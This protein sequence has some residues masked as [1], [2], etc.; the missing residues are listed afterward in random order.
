MTTF[1]KAE[2]KGYQLTEQY[3]LFG[4]TDHELLSNTDKS[5]IFEFKDPLLESCFYHTEGNKLTHFLEQK[6]SGYALIAYLAQ[7]ALDIKRFPW[8]KDR[9]L[10]SH[11]ENCTKDVE[12]LYA[13]LTIERINALIGEL[14]RLYEHTQKHLKAKGLTHV[15]LVRH[16]TSGDSHMNNSRSSYTSTV[17]TLKTC[18]E[19]AEVDA[20]EFEMDVV[21]SYSCSLG[22]YP[23]LQTVTLYREVPIEDVLCCSAFLKIN[24]GGEW[25]ILNRMPDGIVSFKP[26]DIIF[27]DNVELLITRKR[28]L[29]KF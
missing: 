25:H 9:I 17:A 11:F 1:E 22:S 23:Q 26:Q 14:K 2:R 24:E 16:I 7:Y 4:H 20:V 6:S 29:K 27:S 3:R 10:N 12:W 21:N 15:N 8:T 19:I 5:L 28:E 18:A 13:Q